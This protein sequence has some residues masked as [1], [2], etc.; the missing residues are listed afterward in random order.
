[1]SEAKWKIDYGND[2]GPDDGGFWEWWT[3]TDGTR[4]FKADAEADA[5]WLCDLLNRGQAA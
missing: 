5:Q 1:M 4:A 2:V 3:V